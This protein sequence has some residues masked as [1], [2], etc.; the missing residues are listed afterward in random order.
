MAGRFG[1]PPPPPLEIHGANVADKWKKFRLAWNSYAL[2]TE[3]T[4]KPEPVQV[5]TLLTIIGEDARDVF[6]TFDEGVTI[7]LRP[8]T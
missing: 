7:N 3:L 1:L 4:K 6:S 8:K 2:A 5:A